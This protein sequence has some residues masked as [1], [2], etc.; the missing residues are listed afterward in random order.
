[1]REGTRPGS[2]SQSQSSVALARLARLPRLLGM[3]HEDDNS[4]LFNIRE[5]AR[6]ERGRVAG[7]TEAAAAALTEAR[8]RDAA[9]ERRWAE[10]RLVAERRFAAEETAEQRKQARIAAGVERIEAERQLTQEITAAARSRAVAHQAQLDR[11]LE[12]HRATARRPSGV[13]PGVAAA[14]AAGAL[15]LALGG[16]FGVLAPRLEASSVHEVALAETTLVDEAQLHP[17]EDIAAAHDAA[18]ASN[19]GAPVADAVA[20]P[21]A[22]DT[23]TDAAR[24]GAHRRRTPSIERVERSGARQNGGLERFD[25]SVHSSPTTGIDFGS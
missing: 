4:V 2:G 1:M 22:N 5:L 13:R 9:E 3:P 12:V 6:M 11:E 8:E 14:I 7:E 18:S 21:S 19:G 23:A 20:T 24:P 16:W 15:S 17:D 10:A 25:L